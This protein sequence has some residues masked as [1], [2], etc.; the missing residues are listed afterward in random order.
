MKTWKQINK[1]IYVF[2]EMY[3]YRCILVSHGVTLAF[4]KPER[5]IKSRWCQ[6]IQNFGKTLRT[7]ITHIRYNF[8]VSPAQTIGLMD[9]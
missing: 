9:S 7:D 6:S 5:C 3:I 8:N 1:P 4:C 2:S